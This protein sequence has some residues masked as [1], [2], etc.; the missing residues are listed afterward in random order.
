[1][2]FFKRI[3][4]LI[5]VSA[6]FVSCLDK[7]EKTLDPYTAITKFSVGSFRV[8]YH[9]INI[10]GRDTL[11]YRTE[12][13]SMYP[14]TI[15]QLSN[16]IYNA[17][18]I[19]MGAKLDKVT[20]S[21]SSTGTVYYR[22]YRDEKNYVDTIWTSS[23][24][25]NLTEPLTFIV[26]SPDRKNRREY[27]V[28]LNVHKADPDSMSWCGPMAGAPSIK[29]PTSLIVKEDTIY[30]FGLSTEGRALLQ[31]RPTNMHAEWSVE[32]EIHGIEP[33]SMVKDAI[34]SFGNIFA[35]LQDGELY[36]S[37]DGVTWDSPSTEQLS[38]LVRVSD[39]ESDTI[40]WAVT[41][42]NRLVKSS[43]LIDWTTV[44]TID[45]SF[46][47]KGI[48]MVS[49]PL[50]SNPKIL[51][52]ILVGNAENEPTMY[53]KVSV[54]TRLSTDSVWVRVIPST[55]NSFALPALEGL[56]LIYYDKSLYAYGEN[57][58]NFYQSQDN[59]ITWRSCSAFYDE[60]SSW[61][62]YMKFPQPLQ[63]SVGALSALSND[64]W[65]WVVTQSGELWR[66]GINRLVW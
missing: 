24:S 5:S 22:K 30:L 32:T 11:V 51:R 27:S 57:L 45:S 40:C 25:I 15:N 39:R 6:L 3:L 9:D 47:T 29:H 23:D 10:Y 49:Y 20:L 17:D 56:S 53:G 37:T 1:M 35:I 13:G 58:T 61:N 55:T 42:D 2:R 41:A 36:T 12:S 50:K 7:R 43:N 4:F 18:S 64:N 52:S 34:R 21:I 44:Q 46:P 54:W 28:E 33:S 60:Y 38:S 65:I 66:G 16:R 8:W 63:G 14:M 19:P 62:P 59:G 48:S 26:L 31:C